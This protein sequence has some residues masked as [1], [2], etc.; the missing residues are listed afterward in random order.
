[1][2]YQHIIFDLDHTLWDFDRNAQ[3]ILDRLYQE[4]LSTIEHLSQDQFNRV[5]QSVNKQLWQDYH[6]NRISKSDLRARRFEL[7]LTELG[8]D[9]SCLGVSC[10][11]LDRQFVEGTAMMDGVFPHCHRVLGELS[12]HYKL[13]IMTNGFAEVQHRK[14]ASA[15][16]DGYFE[17]LFISEDV[18]ANK[19]APEIFQHAVDTLGVQ[20]GECLM[21]GDNLEAD[22]GGARN[23]GMDQVWFNPSRLVTQQ[24]ATYEIQCLSELIDILL[25]NG[26]AA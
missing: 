13:H 15:K 1:M 7:T 23:V 21:V 6:L 8:V 11:E 20:F 2:K 4:H 10:I 12:R 16:L 18:G 3:S 14:M 26:A 24:H 9:F 19:P 5:Y 22:I 17:N 25:P